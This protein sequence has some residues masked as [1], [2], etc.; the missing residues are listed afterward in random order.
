[1]KDQLREAEAK[2]KKTP[3]RILWD[4]AE[5]A[6]RTLKHPNI[7]EFQAQLDAILRAAE[8]GG[9][10]DD[11]IDSIDELGDTMY[12][13]TTW[14]ARGCSNG[15]NY[16]FPASIIDAE[17][18]IKAAT[19]WGLDQRITATLQRIENA[20]GLLKSEDA[21]LDELAQKLAEARK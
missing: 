5:G 1:M 13:N 21:H 7:S 19:I 6:I 20:K 16:K 15:S 12:V 11:T 14:Y 3:L 2:A 17:D 18:P 10:R 9:V 8:V 4:E